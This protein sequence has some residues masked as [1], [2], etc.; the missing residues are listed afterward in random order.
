MPRIL[1]EMMRWWMLMSAGWS[2]LKINTQN[3]RK[4]WFTWWHHGVCQHFMPLLLACLQDTEGKFCSQH[5]IWEQQKEWWP[6]DSVL[7]FH[8]AHDLVLSFLSFVFPFPLVLLTVLI[9]PIA[10]T[11]PPTPAP[12]CPP[13]KAALFLLSVGCLQ[14]VSFF[15]AFLMLIP[16]PPVLQLLAAL[17]CWLHK[18]GDVKVKKVTIARF[19]S[20]SRTVRI[21][22]ATSGCKSAKLQGALEVRSRSDRTTRERTAEWWWLQTSRRRVWG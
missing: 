8:V 5:W 14:S 19:C 15:L 9:V 18:R 12:R 7:F 13:I 22:P 16:P 11:C 21:N 17:T 4:G 10:A 20:P 1:W 2:P 6:Q 3:L